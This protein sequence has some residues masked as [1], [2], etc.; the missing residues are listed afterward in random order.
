MARA[1]F[2]V[3]L[4]AAA[5]ALTLPVACGSSSGPTSAPATRAS[6]L[7]SAAALPRGLVAGSYYRYDLPHAPATVGSSDGVLFVDAG[8][9]YVRGEIQGLSAT[10]H[11]VLSIA[12][13]EMTFSHA[14][15]G[16]EPCD[17]SDV[18]VYRFTVAGR[19]L[20]LQVVNDTCPQREAI[21]V[22]HDL[23]LMRG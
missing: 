12:G 1:S 2:V 8:R 18:G 20:R 22:G 4:A 17:T 21:L 10:E 15:P 9:A 6:T 14:L 16:G 19:V 11:D 5:A 3:R 13:D 7:A 23:T